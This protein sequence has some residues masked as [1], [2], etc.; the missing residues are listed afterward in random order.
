[1]AT[2]KENCAGPHSCAK[3][4]K[5]STLFQTRQ[6]VRWDSAAPCNLQ[7]T[8]WQSST[9]AQTNCC[10]YCLGLLP[11]R[12]IQQRPATSAVPTPDIAGRQKRLNLVRT[13]KVSCILKRNRLRDTWRT[14]PAPSK[15]VFFTLSRGEG[16]T[17]NSCLNLL[18]ERHW[19][20]FQKPLFSSNN[21]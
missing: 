10:Y 8:A 13:S 1:M 2:L 7:Q 11:L 12:Q 15:P 6:S 19:E 5:F 9:V 4:E 20:S 16:I 21:F 18:R 17:I 14:N 3:S